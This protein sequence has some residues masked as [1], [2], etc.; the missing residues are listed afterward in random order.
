MFIAAKRNY[1]IYTNRYQTL[2]ENQI[3]N[4]IFTSF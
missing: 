3:S 1:A 2:Y 4:N